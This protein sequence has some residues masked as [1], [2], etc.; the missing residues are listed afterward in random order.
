MVR[1]EY[2]VVMCNFPDMTVAEKICKVLLDER[3]AA[4]ITLKG[5]VTN[6]F[7]WKNKIQKENECLAIIKTMSAK[8]SLLETKILALHPHDN[9]ELVALPITDSTKAYYDFIYKQVK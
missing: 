7:Y 5:N 9:P 1:D 6:M 3:L 4:S 8:F 2:I